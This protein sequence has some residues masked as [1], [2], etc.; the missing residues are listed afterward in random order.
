MRRPL[1]MP[2]ARYSKGRTESESDV[3]S[4]AVDVCDKN[5]WRTVFNKYDADRDGRVSIQD[6][7]FYWERQAADLEHDFPPSVYRE[8]LERFDWDRDG[9]LTYE[10]FES[11]MRVAVKNVNYPKFCTLVKFA[12]GTVVAN[13]RRETFVRS[14]IQEY[15]CLPPPLFIT[16]ISIAQLGVY[17]YYCIQLGEWSASGP[18]PIESPLIYDPYRRWQA[19]RFLTY[20]FIHIGCYHIIFNLLMQLMLG[21]PLEMVHKWYRVG[22][23]YLIGVI[24]GS[25]GSSLS[26][27]RTL[28]AGASGGVYALIAAH[29]AS[30]IINFSEMEFGWLRLGILLIFGITDTSV[31][32][33]ERY[34]SSR[35]QAISYSAHL[36]GAFVGL[37]LGVV[38][39]RNLVVKKWETIV[40]IVSLCFCLVFFI[41][42]VSVNVFASDY[43]PSPKPAHY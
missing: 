25:L 7:Y 13:N 9:N 42:A 1:T 19:W 29:L 43:Y 17:I 8:L 27:P 4:V 31:A 11:M 21:I 39:L 33:Y 30:V 36:A 14:Y 5:N 23:V 28:L 3:D 18:L 35:T 34:S 2:N 41:I 24:G 10:E 16:F 40:R 37:T 15:S 12:A 32:V 38:V 6:L 22:A 26:D 20:M